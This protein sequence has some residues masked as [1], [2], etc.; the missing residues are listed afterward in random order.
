[1]FGKTLFLHYFESFIQFYIIDEKQNSI[2]YQDTISDF[3]TEE[4]YQ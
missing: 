3:E 4:S 2:G 1:M